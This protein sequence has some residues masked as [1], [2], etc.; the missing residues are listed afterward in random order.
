MDDVPSWLSILVH[1]L[2]VGLY[3]LCRNRCLFSFSSSLAGKVRGGAGI[4]ALYPRMHQVV[5]VFKL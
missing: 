2:I 5:C 1:Q 3:Q 4:H